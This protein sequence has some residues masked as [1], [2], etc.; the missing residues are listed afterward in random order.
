M[1][2]LPNRSNP[3]MVPATGTHKTNQAKRP[4]YPGA[5]S[6]WQAM[7]SARDGQLFI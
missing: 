4:G 7:F 1:V 5:F 3:R 2:G 6:I